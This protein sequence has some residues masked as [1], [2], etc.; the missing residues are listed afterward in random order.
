[1]IGA[2]AKIPLRGSGMRSLAGFRKGR[3]LPLQKS[4]GNC[5]VATQN[6]GVLRRLEPYG[7]VYRKCANNCCSPSTMAGEMRSS[8]VKPQNYV[9]RSW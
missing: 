9:P 8:M 1:M 7:E 6:A 3:N 4:S 5:N 2:H